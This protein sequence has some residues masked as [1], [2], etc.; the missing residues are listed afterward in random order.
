MTWQTIDSPLAFK[1]PEILGWG[2]CFSSPRGMG[3]K[4]ERRVIGW[5][6]DGPSGDGGW[7]VLETDTICPVWMAPT[8]WMPLSS[9][10]EVEP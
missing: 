8:H 5:R 7:L 4:P 1:D 3:K 9:P 10:P 2:L 6:T